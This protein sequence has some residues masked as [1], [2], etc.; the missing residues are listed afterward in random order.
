MPFVV[1]DPPGTKYVYALMTEKSA[2]E[3]YLAVLSGP[4]I[5]MRDFA[6]GVQNMLKTRQGV[7]GASGRCFYVNFGTKQE[8]ENVTGDL[9]YSCFNCGAVSPW[10]K[11]CERCEFTRYCSARCQSTHWKKSHKEECPHISFDRR[12]RRRPDTHIWYG[13]LSGYDFELWNNIIFPS[14]NGKRFTGGLEIAE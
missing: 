7:P 1:K 2:G 3:Y 12:G 11:L 10:L 14:A 4:D 5:Q 6:L 8:L 9:T 13:E